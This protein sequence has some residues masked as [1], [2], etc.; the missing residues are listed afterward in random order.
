MAPNRVMA[1]SILKAAILYRKHNVI[2]NIITYFH[3]HM[4]ALDRCP[5][6]RQKDLDLERATARSP[7]P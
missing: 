3:G 6:R 1:S 5:H 4:A 2:C 7:S